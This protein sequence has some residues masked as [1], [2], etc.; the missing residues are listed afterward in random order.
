MLECKVNRW[1]GH[2]GPNW[3][4][5]IGFRSKELVDEYIANDPI[6]IFEEKL[7]KEEINTQEQIQEIHDRVTDEV[8]KSYEFATKSPRPDPKEIKEFVFTREP[9][10]LTKGKKG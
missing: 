5:D 6:K 8:E 3:D 2:V 9:E 10:K 4:Y 1:V 7:R